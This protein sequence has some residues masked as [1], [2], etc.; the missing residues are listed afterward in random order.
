MWVRFIDLV[1]GQTEAILKGETARST[2][3]FIELIQKSPGDAPRLIGFIYRYQ[4]PNG[5]E[6]LRQVYSRSG[7]D[8]AMH[9]LRDAG[10]DPAKVDLGVVLASLPGP[11][12]VEAVALGEEGIIYA[13]TPDAVYIDLSTSAPALTRRFHRRFS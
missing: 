5:E 8:E 12:E 9:Q 4:Q 7:F 1:L 6:L 13:I 3:N 11:R 2:V 10:I